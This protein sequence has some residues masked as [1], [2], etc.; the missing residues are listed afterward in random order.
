MMMATL[1]ITGAITLVACLMD[2]AIG[3]YLWGSLGFPLGFL[4]LAATKCL[5]G[6]VSSLPFAP[7]ATGVPYI[8]A[9]WFLYELG[10]VTPEALGAGIGISVAISM[11]VFWGSFGV[12]MMDLPQRKTSPSAE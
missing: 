11:I 5:H 6:I 1:P 8:A 2:I 9:G 7:N 10:G 12:A 4:V 3:Y